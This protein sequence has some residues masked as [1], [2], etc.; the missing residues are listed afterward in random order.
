MGRKGLSFDEKKA[1]LLRIIREEN[2]VFNL[3]ELE[4]KGSKAGIVTQTIKEVLQSLVDD[5]NV[6]QDKV[7]SQNIF[8]SFPSA[9]TVTKTSKISNFKTS[10]ASVQSDIETLTAKVETLRLQRGDTNER[11]ES[12]QEWAKLKSKKISLEK[13][14]QILQLNDPSVLLELKQ[15]SII[16]KESVNRWTDNCWAIKSFIIKKF[17]RTSKEIDKYIGMDADFDYVD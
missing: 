12:L 4:K 10:I 6:N 13:D 2:T 7:G 5:N 3:K 11:K 15:Q 17:N 16:A 1:R 14:L 9:V 8:W